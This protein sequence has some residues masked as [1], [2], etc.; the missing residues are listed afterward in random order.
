MVLD[1]NGHYSRN[2]ST[3]AYYIIRSNTAVF[4]LPPAPCSN[5]ISWFSRIVL[6]CLLSTSE[7]T[8]IPAKRFNNLVSG[9][10]SNLFA[11]NLVSL[12]NDWSLEATSIAFSSPPQQQILSVI[13]RLSFF[14][15]ILVMIPEIIFLVSSAT[16]LYSLHHH[17]RVFS[18]AYL[19][20]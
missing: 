6:V 11:N 10:R 18:V 16:L 12:V 13:E 3:L 20:M 7:V 19:L 17:L 15:E 4:P 5:I 1:V 2:Q 8:K 14:V 9:T